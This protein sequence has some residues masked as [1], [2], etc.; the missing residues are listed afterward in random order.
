MTTTKI[1]CAYAFPRANSRSNPRVLASALR[2]LAAKVVYFSLVAA[3][4]VFVSILLT[5][6][7]P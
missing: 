3:V 7:H 1:I 2:D 4:F 5:G 6:I